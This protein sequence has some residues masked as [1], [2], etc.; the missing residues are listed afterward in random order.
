MVTFHKIGGGVGVEP[1]PAVFTAL[2]AISALHYPVCS[3]ISRARVFEARS[4][5][6]TLTAK[7]G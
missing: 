5:T 4:A 1:T 2:P 7:V 3:P 6:E